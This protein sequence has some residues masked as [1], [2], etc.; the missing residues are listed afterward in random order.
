[1]C[2]TSTR[3]RAA[4]Q[5]RVLQDRSK[6]SRP[7]TRDSSSGRGCR[8]L[9]AGDPRRRGLR[10]FERVRH[11]PPDAPAGRQR[12]ADDDH[13]Q[14]RCFS[15]LRYL[16]R[17]VCRLWATG[18]GRP[19]RPGLA[20]DLRHQPGRLR[21][22][23]KSALAQRPRYAEISWGT[24]RDQASSSWKR[25]RP[26]AP[27]SAL[28]SASSNSRQISSASESGSFAVAYSEEF[29]RR[30]PPL[31]RVELNDGPADRHV[32]DD[33]VHG[34]DVVH[35]VDLIRIHAEVGGRQELHEL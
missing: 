15:P 23:S 31:A 20:D 18:A 32:L 19:S 14:G 5:T 16:L 22:T 12:R 8:G 10:G 17:R 29:S 25:W 35:G 4:S 9:R 13:P 3:S 11:H 28:S 27:I 2:A 30:D 6:G 24:C 34:R 21:L 33:L 7:T 1:M 26:R